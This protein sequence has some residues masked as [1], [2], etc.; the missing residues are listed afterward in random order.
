MS[1]KIPAVVLVVDEDEVADTGSID[2][3]VEEQ[4]RWPFK[5]KL[6][7]KT[8]EVALDPEELRR[9]LDDITAKLEKV[10]ENQSSR[11]VG[12]FRLESFT[13]GLA[14]SASGKVA[15]IAE[16]GVEASIQLQFTRQLVLH[17]ADPSASS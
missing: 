2:K 6:K 4:A 8:E 10:L 9:S 14:V 1:D 7:G 12:G 3:G 17:H 13:V 11:D 5:A 16:A 15:M